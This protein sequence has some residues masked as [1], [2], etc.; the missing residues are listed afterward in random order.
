MRK[1]IDFSIFTLKK[2]SLNRI[3]SK[4]NIKYKKYHKGSNLNKIIPY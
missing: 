2:N 4:K 1:I 3:F